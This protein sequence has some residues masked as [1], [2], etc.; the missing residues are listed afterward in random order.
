MSDPI[1][2]NNSAESTNDYKTTNYGLPLWRAETVTSWLSQMNNA[3]NIIDNVMHALALRTSVTGEPS[4][5]LIDSVSKLETEMQSVSASLV[6]LS[7]LA[8]QVTNLQ[9]Q[10][11]T[12]TQ[13]IQT[14][15]L[16]YTNLDTRM[17]TAE[18]AIQQL[19]TEIEKL[20]NNQ[21]NGGT[22]E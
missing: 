20:Q 15:M 16:N 18:S 4:Q 8:E 22:T 7:N 2:G 10:S 21:N 12:N 6:R 3:M 17:S 19:R 11:A 13:D 5:E 14:L 9:T 1:H